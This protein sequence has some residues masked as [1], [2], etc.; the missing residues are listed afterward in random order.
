MKTSWKYFSG[1]FFL[2]TVIFVFLFWPLAV[3][4]FLLAL[5]GLTGV[6]ACNRRETDGVIYSIPQQ[7]RRMDFGPEGPPW[8]DQ[9]PPITIGECTIFA[10]AI[11]S[12]T[13]WE[14]MGPDIEVTGGVRKARP[15]TARSACI[16]VILHTGDHFPATGPVAERLR[17]W[18][19]CTGDRPA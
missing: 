7:G 9:E 8:A 12:I 19:G 15:D 18:F 11:R 17:K 2:L 6:D 13:E 1:L 4:T 3:C 16:E 14:A 5:I 10:S